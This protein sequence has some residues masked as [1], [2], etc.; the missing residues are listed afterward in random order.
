MASR[1]TT[2]APRARSTAPTRPAVIEPVSVPP[3]LVERDYFAEMREA[4]EMEIDAGPFVSNIAAA[5]IVDRL[6]E[7]DPDLLFGWLSAHA[8]QIVR[9]AILDI[10]KSRRSSARV[11]STRSVFN[12]ATEQAANGDL[13]GLDGFRAESGWLSVRFV[14]EGERRL[15]ADMTGKEVLQVADDYRQRAQS[16]LLEEA[17]MRAVAKRCGSRKVSDVFTNA[18][19]NQLRQS[20]AG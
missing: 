16:N 2:L 17:F 12:K 5:A 8:V 10:D 18:K 1:S 11:Q 3:A 15:L 7:K 19:L 14:V 20:I 13:T 9:V 4:I 6:R